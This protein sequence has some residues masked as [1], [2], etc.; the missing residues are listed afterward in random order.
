MSAFIRFLSPLGS[1]AFFCPPGDR[2][3]LKDDKER[4]SD[5]VS[6]AVQSSD[7]GNSVG[8]A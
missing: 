3:F 6:C 2:Q 8:L 5:A 1:L 4:R 7:R